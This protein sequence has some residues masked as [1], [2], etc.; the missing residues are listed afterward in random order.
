MERSVNP[1]G[2]FVNSRK[3][4][5]DACGTLRKA[6]SFGFD[7]E[8]IRERSFAPQLCLIQA[9][10]D[11]FIVLIDPFEVD[12]TEFWDLLLD[13]GIEKIVHAGSQDMEMCY[14]QT[15]N[16]PQNTFDIQIA[17]GM[18]GLE[19][20]LSYGNLVN[21]VLGIELAKDST[22]SEWSQRPLT[23]SQLHYAVA[24]VE[25]LTAARR[26]LQERLVELNR[27]DWMRQ[28]MAPLEEAE[29]YDS[30]PNK[31]WKRVK[32]WQRYGRETLAV[33]RELAAWR[34]SAAEEADV[35]L[36]TLLKDQLLTS[37]A[38]TKPV[39][40]N[41]L[42]ELKGFPRPLARRSGKD[43]LQAI[44]RGKEV[45]KTDQP[46]S[47]PSRKH[48][49]E[50]KPLVN[51]A[52]EQGQEICLA[53]RMNPGLLA[54]RSDYADLVHELKSSK[55]NT[56]GLK[57]TSSWRWEFAGKRISEILTERMASQ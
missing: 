29:P 38:R 26:N 27:Q 2:Y 13:P 18:A 47:H 14:L 44:A 1:A 25:Y 39:S 7:T 40:V 21:E 10:T 33:L 17:A 5:T 28:E 52:L 43:I 55:S 35:P 46:Q 19:Y 56:N 15:G 8:F 3:A 22:F 12:L 34:M 23:E 45:P 51:L 31:A 42:A 20:P 9:A 57:L 6:G 16:A 32:G 11:D 50:D 53:K 4:M 41:A 36:R 37:V 49:H 48:D 30:E 54:S 24:D